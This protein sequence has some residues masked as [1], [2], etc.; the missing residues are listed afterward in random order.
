MGPPPPL[1]C[2]CYADGDDLDCLTC[3]E[4]DDP[5]VLGWLDDPVKWAADAAW[6]GVNVAVDVASNDCVQF[7][8]AATATVVIVTTAVYTGGA[9]VAG[10]YFV[11]TS[12]TVAANSAT[13]VGYM[14]IGGY[15]GAQS[16]ADFGAQAYESGEACIL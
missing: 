5:D 7:V 1:A 10:G 2:P 16:L 14:S 11:A 3:D 12:V 9:L 6:S 8:V 15:E 4:G 13:Y